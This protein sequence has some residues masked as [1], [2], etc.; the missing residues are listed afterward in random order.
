MGTGQ[1]MTD[2]ASIVNQSTLRCETTP[3]DIGGGCWLRSKQL[4]SNFRQNVINMFY[5][6]S[7]HDRE[8]RLVWMQVGFA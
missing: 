6:D 4:E 1:E 8:S 5:Q 2:R 3:N 7:L